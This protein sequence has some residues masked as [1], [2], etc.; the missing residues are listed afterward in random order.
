MDCKLVVSALG[1]EMVF[2]LIAEVIASA[3]A[4]ETFDTILIPMLFDP[5]LVVFI[6]GKDIGF[7]G[8]KIKNGFM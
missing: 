7:L 2:E 5:C 3:V 4:T 8:N 6:I 1:L